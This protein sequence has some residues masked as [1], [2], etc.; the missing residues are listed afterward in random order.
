MKHKSTVILLALTV[1]MGSF[2]PST[3]A[4]QQNPLLFPPTD[5][6]GF[7]PGMVRL[8]HGYPNGYSLVA[9]ASPTTKRVTVRY[10]D[11]LEERT[12]RQLLGSTTGLSKTID[13]KTWFWP[14]AVDFVDD[15]RKLVVVGISPQDGKTTVIEEWIFSAGSPSFVE[16]DCHYVPCQLIGSTS[17]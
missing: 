2:A 6:C 8:G 10:S 11:R 5:W 1:G 14:V 15:G 16:S 9:V 13:F 3:H 4:V 12:R 7:L 17:F